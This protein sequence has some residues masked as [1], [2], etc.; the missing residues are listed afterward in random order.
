MGELRKHLLEI[1]AVSEVPVE[2]VSLS[3]TSNGQDYINTNYLRSFSATKW[4]RMVL[5]EAIARC[6]K[7][8][9]RKI[10]RNLALKMKAASLAT[11]DLYYKQVCVL[12]FPYGNIRQLS[13]FLTKYWD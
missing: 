9:L 8:K 2:H 5:A 4:P 7:H 11:G 6:C 3:V 13:V 1:E 12:L 10:L